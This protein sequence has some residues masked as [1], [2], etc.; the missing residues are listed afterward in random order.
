MKIF[1]TAAF[2][3]AAELSFVISGPARQQE[4]E[5]SGVTASMDEL[6]LS[7]GVLRLT[8][9]LKNTGDKPASSPKALDFSKVAL[10]DSRSNQKHFALKDPDGRYLAGPVSDWNG[11]GR[12]FVR[13]PAGGQ[14]LVWA[15]FEAVPAGTKV[16]VQMP[17]MFPFEGVE[18]TAGAPK[19]DSQA[20]G[21]AVALTARLVSARRSDGQLKIQLRIG[22]S[23]K[24]VPSGQ[25]I[26]YADV[27]V[28]DPNSRQKY[29]LLKDSEG[30]FQA[31][32]VSDNN[33]GG[34]W[35]ASSVRPATDTL[36]N[37]TFPAPPDSVTQ[38][39]LMIPDF[40]PLEGIS[41]TGAG[42][43]T[44]SGIGVA[45]KSLGLE[46]ALRELNAQVSAQEIRINLGADVLF[47]FDKADIRPVALPSLD[48]VTT[49]L[50]AYPGAQVDING[51]ADGKGNADY[52]Q[53]LS[54]R[55]ASAVARWLVEHS[56]LPAESFHALGWGMKQPLAP[57]TN[58]DGTDNPEGRQK[59]RRVE[60]LIRRSP[61][62]A[63]AATG[64]S[65]SVQGPDY[66]LALNT[67]WTYHLH[68]EMGEGVHFG[69]V[70]ATWANGNVVDVTMVSRV[71][72]T[73]IIG[74]LKYARVESQVN[75]RPWMTEWF[76][77]APEGLMLGKTFD[78]T[79][80]RTVVMRPAQK[81]LSPTLKTG[82]A[83]DWK[84]PDAPVS[85]HYSIEG[86]EKVT[87]PAGNY[88]SI[89]LSVLVSAT[90]PGGVAVTRNS[91]WFVA[92]VGYVKQ[93]TESLLGSHLLSRLRLELVKFESGGS[94]A[95]IL[96]R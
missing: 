77:L 94:S 38:L 47:D 3:L 32:P 46:G 20:P 60:V 73:E 36:M 83:W 68:E 10:M 13:V 85:V 91:R 5:I 63:S 12:W 24:A 16:S 52:N 69:D 62:P 51:H 29:A 30:M 33:E 42:G 75:D 81:T 95:R 8:I 88:Q 66:P 53:T 64:I 92:G 89:R 25:A 55:R 39:D 17:L 26:R 87:V 71:L 82:E 9:T 7:N 80:G 19:W 44:A 1:R 50:K 6:R 74:T 34:R 79:E 2:L 28:L 4:T 49:V 72:G 76:C 31:Q 93:E 67:I 84:A 86:I 70:L 27:F 21:S 90:T 59:N 96:P 54:E 11:G 35:F 43:G 22:N 48:N 78:P 23:G 41:I 56:G 37:L 57:N 14:A 18:V 45:G 61:T 65:P 40:V 58:P 15:Y